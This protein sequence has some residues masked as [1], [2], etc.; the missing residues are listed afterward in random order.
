[1]HFRSTAVV[2]AIAALCP[3]AAQAGEAGGPSMFSFSGFGTLGAVHSDE[4]KADYVGSVFQPNG[5]GRT[6]SIDYG[7]DSKLGAQVN[8]RF[9]DK[10]SGVVQVIAQHQHDNS[11]SPRV[12]WAN[13]KY[14]LTPAFSARVGRIVMPTLLVSDSRNV[15]YANH[16]VRAPQE[17]YT[18]AAITS[19]DG[20][21]A[22]YR[23]Q[24]GSAN[25]TL[26]AFYGT[27]TA[28]LPS[29][30]AESDPSWGINNTVQIGSL[31]LRA[32]IVRTKLT[33]DAAQI[34]PLIAGLA[35][36]DPALAQ[37]YKLDGMS[38]G[39]TT[40]GAMYDP[41]D[42]F[43]MTEFA[44]LRGDGLMADSRAWYASGGYRFGAFTPYVT[45]AQAKASIEAEPVIPGAEA[46]IGGLNATKHLMNG[47]QKSFSVGMR[48]DFMPSAALKLQYDRLDI[49]TN[50]NGRL[51]NAAP[52]F[53]PGKVNVV[54]VAVDFVF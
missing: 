37:K 36:V 34:N 5:A 6:R 15:G 27:S 33:L 26:N 38:I 9:T 29:G 19:N 1:M 22:T 42:W 13:L 49:G 32:G 24:I 45:Y 20:V 11:S 4:K 7:V 14:E 44:A 39:S 12:E 47:V 17:V 30:R 50:S 23:S 51:T 2:L 16:W 54:S 43:V 53:Q 48:W 25:N 3:F 21:D 40:V 10:L 31:T 28:R 46:L 41:G 35:M 52:D 8:A 18:V